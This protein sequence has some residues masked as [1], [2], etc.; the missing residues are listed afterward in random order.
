MDDALRAM[1]EQHAGS[2]IS[3]NEWQ[4]AKPL[5]EQ[6]LEWIIHRE[7]DAGGERRKPYY[8]AQL[9]AEAVQAARLI[10]YTQIFYELNEG[11]EAPLAEAR[12]T[13]QMQPHYS[14]V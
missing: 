6:K 8:I 4:T 1:A 13:S 14:M 10:L 5:A 3:D 7:G 2:C 9:I 12:G 11:K